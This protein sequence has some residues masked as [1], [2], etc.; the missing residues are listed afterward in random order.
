MKS[1]KA[2]DNQSSR[3]WKVGL[4]SVAGAALIGVTGGL[5]APLVAAGI[6]SVMGGL[7]RLDSSYS[8]TLLL[9]IFQVLEQLQQPDIWALLLAAL[10]LSVASSVPTVVA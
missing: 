2:D 4:A 8:G 9:T 1:S 7:G 3:K 5:A 6:G 10:S